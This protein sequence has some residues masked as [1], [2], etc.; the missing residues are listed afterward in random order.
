ML[1]GFVQYKGE[2]E[3]AVTL[4][5]LGRTA[6]L[7]NFYLLK[8]IMKISPRIYRELLPVWSGEKHQVLRGYS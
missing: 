7:L 4:H 1:D 3:E 2:G 8:Y 5:R 6:W